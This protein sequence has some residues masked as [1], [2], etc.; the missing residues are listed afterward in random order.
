MHCTDRIVEEE[1][2]RGE[3]VEDRHVRNI[4]PHG[5]REL[6]RS[7]LFRLTVDLAQDWCVHFEPQIAL[8]AVSVTRA[9]ACSRRTQTRLRLGTFYS[10]PGQQGCSEGGIRRDVGRQELL[11]E[12]AYPMQSTI[13]TRIPVCKWVRDLQIL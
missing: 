3:L 11:T 10:D 1:V 4:V 6:Q 9:V 7:T 5:K 2:L 13:H 8:A 12:L